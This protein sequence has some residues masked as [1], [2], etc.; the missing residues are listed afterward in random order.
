MLAL[1]SYVHLA[2]AGHSL[3]EA[4]MADLSVLWA[5]VFTVGLGVFFPVEQEVTRMT[6]GR[7][8]TGLDAAPAWW[9]GNAAAAILF[10]VLAATLLG[11]AVPIANLLYAGDVTLVLVTL[12]GMFG[13]A[14]ASPARG[15]AAGAGRFDLYGRQLGLDGVLRMAIAGA[16]ALVGLRTAAAFGAVLAMAPVLAT[17][18]LLGPVRR[19]SGRPGPRAAEAPVR[20]AGGPPGPS[21]AERT[22]RPLR[23]VRA[24]ALEWR[25]FARDLGPLV[26]SALLGQFVLNSAIVSARLIEPEQTAL[27]AALLAA[28]VL[29]RV[30]LFVFAALQATLLSGLSSAAA[31]V[32]PER[33]SR[34]LRH[35][36]AVVTGLAVL[37]AVPAIAIGGWLTGVLFAAPPELGPADFAVLALGTWAY[38][39]AL[40]LGQGALALRRH[41]WQMAAWIAGSVVLVLVTLGPGDL[42]TRVELAY[43][44]GNWVVVLGLALVLRSARRGGIPRWR[45]VGRPRRLAWLGGGSRYAG[46]MPVLSGSTSAQPSEDGAA[47]PGRRVQCD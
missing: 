13:L 47:S 32:D 15:I 28:L 6:A 1:A 36:C 16:L 19:A 17:V 31:E 24:P 44:A 10:G 7:R 34:L 45:R 11:G 46:F 20:S 21:A 12:A 9:R 4:G 26:V 38:I 42:A 40:V 14:V 35:A 22:V 3:S 30:P 2:F 25:R 33:F 39:L 29:V 41:R 43:A 23:A 5:V 8:S 27:A 18:A 37:T